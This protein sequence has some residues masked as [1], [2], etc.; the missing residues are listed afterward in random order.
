MI[1]P[2]NVMRKAHRYWVLTEKRAL[3]LQGA[4][5]TIVKNNP[6][7]ELYDVTHQKAKIGWHVETWARRV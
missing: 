3:I 5:T 6:H 1:E 7:P 4:L 2:L